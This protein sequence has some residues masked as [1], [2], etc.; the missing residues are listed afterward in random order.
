MSAL[1]IMENYNLESKVRV[2]SNAASKN[3]T[4]YFHEVEVFFV[5]DL[6]ASSLIESSNR[7]IQTLADVIGEPFFVD[8]MNKKARSLGMKNTH[9]VN[10]TGLDPNDPTVVPNF[11]TV[12]D[13]V[14]LSK[15]LIEEP[16][17]LKMSRAEELDLYQS[18]GVFHHKAVNTNELLE[19]MPNIVGGKTGTTILAGR[20]LLLILE[21]PKNNSFLVNV[22]LSSADSFQDMEQLVDWVKRAY[23]W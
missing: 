18:S 5:K 2:S 19:R 4:N 21:N 10:P 7:A 14:L 6:L 11:S 20:C 17:I 22:V 15:K 12:E 16:E 8:L 13:L 1:V 3:G 23:K 9:F